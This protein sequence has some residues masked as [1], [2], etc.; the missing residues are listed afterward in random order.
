MA[1]LGS[2]GPGCAN[3]HLDLMKGKG[4]RKEPRSPVPPALPCPPLGLTPGLLLALPLQ[5]SALAPPPVLAPPRQP[6]APAVVARMRGGCQ[7]GCQ[8]GC[9]QGGCGGKAGATAGSGVEGGLQG[10]PRAR[11]GGQVPW[12]GSWGR[13]RL[14]LGCGGL[15]LGVPLGRGG[16]GGVW[17]SWG[18]AERGQGVATHRSHPPPPC[19]GAARAEA[20]PLGW[21][22][23]TQERQ[24]QRQLE[25]WP[26][27]AVLAAPAWPHL[28]FLS[29]F[30]I[31]HVLPGAK[32]AARSIER[33]E[34]HRS[35][36]CGASSSAW[37]F[38]HPRSM[39]ASYGRSQ[40]PW[41]SD[42]PKSHL[43]QAN[44]CL[45]QCPVPV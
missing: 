11:A 8:G 38:K 35:G 23:P 22:K 2:S 3:P 14:P 34:L 27:H 44:C 33:A 6:C 26:R 5:P 36:L 32:P 1:P 41:G 7:G 18:A 15:Q 40:R 25:P 30:F 10:W 12:G 39:A 45:Q 16:P 13:P 31:F 24:E 29:R 4:Q 42:A 17:V 37:G 21:L 28:E 9:R 19:I 20:A 43:P